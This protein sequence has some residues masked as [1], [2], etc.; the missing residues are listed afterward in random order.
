[1]I[2]AF[3][4]TA[5]MAGYADGRVPVENDPSRKSRGRICC[6][7]QHGSLFSNVINMVLGL[8][9]HPR[10]TTRVHHSA[11]RYGGVAVRGAWA[12]VRQAADYWGQRVGRCGLASVDCGF[13]TATR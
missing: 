2:S 13:C 1:F 6:D 11:R 8:R 4:G 5:D 9:G 7:A 3:G 12:A 10:E